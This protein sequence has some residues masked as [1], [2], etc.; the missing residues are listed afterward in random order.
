[1]RPAVAGVLMLTALLLAACGRD[2][3]ASSPAPTASAATATATSATSPPA[4]TTAATPAATPTSVATTS[5]TTT[6]AAT[7]AATPVPTSA[8]MPAATLLPAG[9]PVIIENFLFPAVTVPC[10]ATVTW[11]NRDPIEHDVTTADGAFGSKT[12]AMGDTYSARLERA[13]TFMYFCSIHPFMMGTVTV[14]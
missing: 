1:M 2:A 6:S 3:P 10:G 7:A 11:T 5:Q 14:Q 9:T 4:A 13:G 12:L 8:A